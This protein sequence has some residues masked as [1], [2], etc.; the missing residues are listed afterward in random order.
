[1]DVSGQVDADVGDI[2]NGTINVHQLV[3]QTL[4]S[5]QEEV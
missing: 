2:Q 5:L 3:H 1:M 4:L